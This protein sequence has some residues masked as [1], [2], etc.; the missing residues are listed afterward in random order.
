MIG[1]ADTSLT[2]AEI[3]AAIDVLRSG[4]LRQGPQVAAFEQDFAAFVGARHAVASINGSTALHIAFECFI[5]PGDEV[6]VPSF[7]FIATATMVIAAGGVPVMC[8]VDPET[9]L[10]DLDDAAAKTTDRTRA[11]VPVHLFGN[12]CDIGAVMAFANRH[13][14]KIVW[15]AAQA[16]G[17]TFD[18]RG[19]GSFGDYVTYS[20]YP[21]K[22]MFVGEGGMTCTD[23]EDCDTRM[24]LLREHG[25]PS[26][27]RHTMLGYNYRMTDVA[28][29]IGRAQLKRLPDMLARR[30]RNGERLL[31]GLHGLPG[32]TLPTVTPGAHH[33][34]HQFCVLVDKE[35]FG[36]DRDEL[37]VYL[38]EN[39][40][41]SAVH[42][43]MG[44]HQQPVFVEMYGTHHLP[45]TEQL[46]ETILALPVHHGLSDS[47]IDQVV[48]VIREVAAD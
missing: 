4:M 27:Y 13:D 33:A 46:S 16:H 25:M 34:W 8:D 48:E 15:D 6:L 32:L 31:A 41:G 35:G 28:A 23:K 20:F 19:V 39:E 14:L 37:A 11:I 10:I 9:W 45:V 21:T 1:I 40:V 24:R 7:T 43:P 36:L 22:N 3:D 17:A 42:Y 29:A 2:E 47:D 38:R 44:L 26:R 5:K 30:R 18:G 12:V